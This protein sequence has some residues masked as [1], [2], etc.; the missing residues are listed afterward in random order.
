MFISLVTGAAQVRAGNL[1]AY[2]VTSPQR[3][4]SLPDVPAISEVVP[5]FRVE[6]VVRSVWAGAFAAR[7][8]REIACGH[9]CRTG[10]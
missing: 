10:R 4:P 7:H 9:R 2:G 8:Y 1:R 6:C 5:G 3:Q